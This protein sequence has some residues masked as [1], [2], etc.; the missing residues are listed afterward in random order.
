MSIL[1]INQILAIKDAVDRDKQAIDF[2]IELCNIC[3]ETFIKN[4]LEKCSDEEI[5]HAETVKER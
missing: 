3:A 4:S 1:S 2:V 5:V